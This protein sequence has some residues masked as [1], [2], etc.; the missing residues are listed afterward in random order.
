MS[1]G[2]VPSPSLLWHVDTMFRDETAIPNQW[3]PCVGDGRAK[4]MV[5]SETL[6]TV[7]GCSSLDC[8]TCFSVT[9]NFYIVQA[10]VILGFL[11]LSAKPSPLYEK[12][13]KEVTWGYAPFS[14]FIVILRMCV[15]GHTRTH[16]RQSP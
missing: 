14:H 9:E 11:S 5:E 13:L 1:G 16:T 2:V 6:L 4:I 8:S 10:I 15:R 7:G 3:R 12:A